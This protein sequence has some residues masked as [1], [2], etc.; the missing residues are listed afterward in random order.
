M[1]K[2]FLSPFIILSILLILALALGT[3]L[4]T[5]TATAPTSLEQ[6][7][8]VTP[9][10]TPFVFSTYTP[11]ALN[12]KDVYTVFMI[13]DSMTLALGPHGGT[14]NQFINEL[15]K[16]DNIYILIDNYAK[17]STNIL[18]VNDQLT[19][20]TTYWDSTFEPLLSRDFDLILIESFGYNPLSV[21]GSVEEGIKQQNKALEELMTKLITTRPAA[22]ILFVATIAPSRE[23]YAKKVLLDIPVADRIKQAEERMAYIKN[24]IE[25]AQSHNI[26]VV[27]IYEKSLTAT[28]DGDLKYINPDDYIHPSFEGVDFI[29]HEIANFIYTNQILPH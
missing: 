28:G 6:L 21:A 18:S 7:E 24:H 13:G 11:P 1:K 5:K 10:P 17:G 12:R 26:P 25:Y 2:G 20:K 29:G 27:N 8:A 22:R 14:F 4:K 15:Y 16:K 23:N 9:S 3:Y 19:Q